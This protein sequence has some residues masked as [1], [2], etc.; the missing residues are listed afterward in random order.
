MNQKS[1]RNSAMIW[2]SNLLEVE[3]QWRWRTLILWDKDRQSSNRTRQRSE[4]YPTGT[5]VDFFGSKA[6][7]LFRSRQ[8]SNSHNHRL[9]RPSAKGG[10]A[11]AHS[12]T[13]TGGRRCPNHLRGEQRE[14]ISTLALTGRYRSGQTGQT[15]NLLALRLR[16]FESSPAQ[17][18]CRSA[19]PTLNGLFAGHHR[20][21]HHRTRHH[22]RHHSLPRP[23]HIRVR[24]HRVVSP[25]AGGPHSQSVAGLQRFGR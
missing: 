24:H 13:A 17:I 25:L 8:S 10:F 18:L 12:A 19:L 9:R 1:P 4:R 21:G 16:W 7:V 22:H 5:I 14:P 23:R 6:A 15:V 11:T 20:G 2:Q 3:G